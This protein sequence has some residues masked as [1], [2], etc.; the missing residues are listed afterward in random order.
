MSATD[1]RRDT[2]GPA[3]RQTSGGPV[4]A[5]VKDLFFLARIRETGRLAGVPVVFVKNPEELE[6]ALGSDARFV[7]LDLTSGLDYERVFAA[8][9][10]RAV[11]VL[12]FTTHAMAGHTQPWHGRCERV[13]TK[14]TL[15]RE[16]PSLLTEGLPSRAPRL[17]SRSDASEGATC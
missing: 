7:L 10:R 14:E 11:R 4:V 13:V 9:T 1:G 17:D 6:T 3:G 16:L 5:V 12:G 15:T 8:T 2:P